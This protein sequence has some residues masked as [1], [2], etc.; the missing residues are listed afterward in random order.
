MK[1]GFRPSMAWLHSWSGLVI[2]W[3]LF[4]I[5]ITGTAA[6]FKDEISDWMRPEVTDRAATVDALTA[7]FQHLQRT[8]PHAANWYL[9][10]PDARAHATIASYDVT[11]AD[12][13]PVYKLEAFDPVTGSPDGIR[14][15]LGGEFF[16]R[17]HFELQLPYPWGRILAQAEGDEPGV[18]LADLNLDD[19]IST[20]QAIPSLKNERPFA[21]PEGAEA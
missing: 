17:F 19:V 13:Q 20:R 14:Q 9:Y 18:I 10:A 3:L 2:G 7:A 4:A 1:A 6:V 8:H 12:G 15:T 16:Y 5:A 21:A 11:G